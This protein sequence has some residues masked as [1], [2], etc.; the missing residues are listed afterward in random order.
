VSLQP[1]GNLDLA[2]STAFAQV[3]EQAIELAIDVVVIDLIDVETITTEGMVMLQAAMELAFDCD[4]ELSFWS[5]PADISQN[6]RRE[7]DRQHALRL[8]QRLE[9]YSPGF[10]EFL[11]Q[12]EHRQFSP[13][14]SLP[15]TPQPFTKPELPTVQPLSADLYTPNGWQPEKAAS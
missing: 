5:V 2:N 12:Q 13:E 6:L 8:S 1:Q 14:H 3:L 15:P 9:S 7:R 10:Q 11:S 4:K